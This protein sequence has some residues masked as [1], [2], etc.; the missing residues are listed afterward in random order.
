M[1]RFSS[2]LS[3]YIARHYIVALFSLLAIMVGIIFM[4][5]LIELL[6]RASDKNLPFILVFKMA[7]LKIP[8]VSQQ[9]LSFAILF[10]SIFTFWRLTKSNELIIARAAGFSV[11]QFLFPVLLI[12][13]SLGVFK[14]AA[15]NPIST[16]FL[17]KFEQMEN[18][19]LKQHIDLVKFN[20]TGLWL[21]QDNGDNKYTILHADRFNPSNWNLSSVQIFSLTDDVVTSRKDAQSGYLKDN[22]WFF[23]NIVTHNF[24]TPPTQQDY[25]VLRTNIS[26]KEI[27]DSFAS[28]D[29]ISFW[30]LSSFI[31]S[32]EAI[33]FPTIKLK[34]YQQSLLSDPL[35]FIAMVLIAASVSLRPAR[36][37]HIFAI[38]TLGILL[39]FLVFILD[40]FLQAFGLTEQIS[41]FIAAWSAPFITFTL[42]L[43]TLLYLEES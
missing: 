20:E 35:L 39:G 42:A 1:M 41:P 19:H 29:T 5:D 10:S 17:S 15:I 8:E 37:G 7:L 18:N 3:L 14:F 13:F 16:V 6:R 24:E 28:P 33:G 2:T 11:W 30:H 26:P 31:S 36:K 32:I 21:R 38:V 4:L 22:T 25:F 9:L 40:N 43:T 27:E 34:I 23:E 12:A